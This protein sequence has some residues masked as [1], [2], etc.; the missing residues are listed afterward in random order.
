MEKQNKK[1]LLREYNKLKENIDSYKKQKKFLDYKLKQDKI[2]FKQIIGKITVLNISKDENPNLYKIKEQNLKK[3]NNIIT[4][5]FNAITHGLGVI[6]GIIILILLM[7]KSKHSVEIAAYLIY[8]ISF[9]LLFLSSTLYH[10]LSFTRAKKIFRIIDHSSI[11]L[12]IA[13]TYTPYLLI[14]LKNK[15]SF[16][17]FVGIWIIALIG[18]LLNIFMF[19]KTLKIGVLLYIAMGWISIIIVKDLMSIIPPMGIFFLALG[20]L[21]YTGGVY[22]YKKKSMKFSHVIWHL[23]VLGGALLMFISIYLY[24]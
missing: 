22:F 7:L 10:S 21:T 16:Y 11:F 6:L 18:I 20:G 19:N 9:I 5:V 4:E 8:S 13:G 15:S 23:F 3:K 12:L 2:K 17:Y 1:S 24:V 14:S